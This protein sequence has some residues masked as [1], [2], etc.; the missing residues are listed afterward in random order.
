MKIYDD[1]NNNNQDSFWS[2]NKKIGLFDL[3]DLEKK[4]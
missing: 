1:N 3:K 2:P 4:F